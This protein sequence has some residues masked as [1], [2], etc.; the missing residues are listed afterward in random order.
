MFL[1]MEA[2][3]EEVGAGGGTAGALLRPINRAAMPAMTSASL[4]APACS[5]AMVAVVKSCR[6]A[7]E[8]DRMSTM[9]MFPKLFVLLF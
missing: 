2:A 4:A 3:V 1:G 9:R 7:D 8:R 6:M 5:G